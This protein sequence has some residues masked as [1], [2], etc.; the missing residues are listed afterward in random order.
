MASEGS[1]LVSDGRH[2]LTEEFRASRKY[3]MPP[4]RARTTT[5]EP[6]SNHGTCR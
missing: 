5:I 2:G 6:I 3:P 1:L 4:I